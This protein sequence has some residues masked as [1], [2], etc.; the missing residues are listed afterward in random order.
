MFCRERWVAFAIS[1]SGRGPPCNS[2]LSHTN[3]RK[4]KFAQVVP[5]S[6]LRPYQII[7]SRTALIKLKAWPLQ[8]I[9][10]VTETLELNLSTKTAL[11]FTSEKPR[12]FQASFL[13]GLKDL[14]EIEVGKDKTFNI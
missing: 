14:L 13:G 8:R 2:S 5:W 11:D 10:A 7:L 12:K 1:Y 6:L 4:R 3:Y 9:V